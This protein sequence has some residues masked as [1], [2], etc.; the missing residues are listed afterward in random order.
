MLTLAFLLISLS[1]P[2]SLASPLPPPAPQLVCH[3]R[4]LIQG[5]GTVRVCEVAK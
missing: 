3:T 4:E 5:S 2:T 1:P